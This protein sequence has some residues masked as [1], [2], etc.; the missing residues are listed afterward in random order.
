MLGASGQRLGRPPDLEFLQF[1]DDAFVTRGAH[2]FEIWLCR[3]A[4]A[5]L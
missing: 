5:K 1:Y 3:G 2:S 4:H